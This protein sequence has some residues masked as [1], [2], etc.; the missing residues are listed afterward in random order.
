MQYHNLFLIYDHLNVNLQRFC[1]VRTNRVPIFTVNKSLTPICFTTPVPSSAVIEESLMPLT[2][3]LPKRK[4]IIDALS[5]VTVSERTEKQISLTQA[6]N[7][8]D[9]QEFERKVRICIDH[10]PNENSK[11]KRP[12]E[13]F[14]TKDSEWDRA[15]TEALNQL[16]KRN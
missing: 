13:S 1:S 6:L 4:Y 14:I 15:R 10:L 16:S 2:K 11:T 7:L 12:K 3:V 5:P 8:S 9:T